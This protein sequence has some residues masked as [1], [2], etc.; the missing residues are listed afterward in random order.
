MKLNTR[1]R[2]PV[3]GVGLISLYFGLVV[4]GYGILVYV[5]QP[6]AV[7]RQQ[8]GRFEPGDLEQIKGEVRPGINL[9]E[10]TVA[11]D[12][13]ISKGKE[14]YQA[15]CTVCHGTDGKGDGPGGMALNPKPRNFHAADGWTNGRTI[16]AVFS[17]LT[18]GITARGMLAYDY[19]PIEDR[20]ALAHYVRSKRTDSPTVTDNDLQRLDQEFKL[21][22][23]IKQAHQIPV[24]RA[25]EVLINESKDE[26]KVIDRL[27]K[28]VQS[29]ANRE[30][31]GAR[32]V[33]D[34]G[35]DLQATLGILYKSRSAWFGNLSSFQTIVANSVRQGG[36][37]AEVNQWSH[38]QWQNAY[39]YANTRL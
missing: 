6:E 27:V 12:A 39:S 32:L 8:L 13:Q 20:F 11:S 26:L 10:I 15:N 22:Q 2:I 25:V 7:M 17:T 18:K 28:S 19:L 4:I 9:R 3:P 35:A 29:D 16:S 37:K 21:S 14:L 5:N 23:G 1:G 30:I 36:V 24:S 33:M 34:M 31:L 38:D